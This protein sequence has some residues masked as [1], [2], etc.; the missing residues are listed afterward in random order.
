M[1][2]FVY[3]AKLGE[4]FFLQIF[5]Q[6]Y[7]FFFFLSSFG[8]PTTWKFMRLSFFFFFQLLFTLSIFYCS[9]F[10]C[11]VFSLPFPFWYW[12][13]H[14]FWIWILYFSSSKISI[15]FSLYLPF[16]CW[17][18]LF[19]CWNFLFF[20]CFKLV[21]SCSLKHCYDSFLKNLDSRLPR[22]RDGLQ[23]WG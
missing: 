3:F 23:T 16:L 15:C 4:I 21:Y 5:S 6:P 18:F 19:L 12:V 9:I 10:N 13:I 20:I 14:Y 2:W 7:P 17:E 11:T 22:G 1:A 8:T